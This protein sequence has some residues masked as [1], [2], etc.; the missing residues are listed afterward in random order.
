MLDTVVAAVDRD[1]QRRAVASRV[2][3]IQQGFGTLIPREQEMGRWRETAWRSASRVS[4][5]GPTPPFLMIGR[6]A[7][8]KETG[9]D[10]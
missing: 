3:Q 2:S 10:N 9:H 8:N 1:R 6:E 7:L 5:R 4:I